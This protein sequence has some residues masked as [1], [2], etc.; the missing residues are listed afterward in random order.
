[1]YPVYCFCVEKA[2]V[3]VPTGG[4]LYAM[5][6]FAL[7]C[8]LMLLVN[9]AGGGYCAIQDGRRAAIMASRAGGG[10]SSCRS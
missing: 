1:M 10:G 8:D 6:M 3:H 7:R 5:L 4:C 2:V 9:E